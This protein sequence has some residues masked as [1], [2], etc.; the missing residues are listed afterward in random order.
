ML[1]KFTCWLY[2]CLL[3]RIENAMRDVYLGRK[4]KVI[5]TRWNIIN[6]GTPII[7]QLRTDLCNVISF[8]HGSLGKWCKTSGSDAFKIEVCHFLSNY[9]KKVI[10]RGYPK[11]SIDHR[12]E[13]L[14]LEIVQKNRNAKFIQ[15]CKEVFAYANEHKKVIGGFIQA[16][17][18][19]PRKLC[20]SKVR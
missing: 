12:N 6:H 19:S 18:A 14:V 7:H 1:I 10:N 5:E 2:L 11:D 13:Q 20:S 4:E 8:V 9:V 3:Y 17:I 16:S 15:I